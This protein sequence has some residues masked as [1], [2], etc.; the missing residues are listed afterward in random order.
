MSEK[1]HALLV[2][3]SEYEDPHFRRLE[4]PEKDVKALARV[5]GDQALGAFHDVKILLNEPR[6]ALLLQIEEF[7]AERERDDLL[8][9]YFS[10]HG[11]KDE[12]GRLYYAAQN[13][14]HKR[15]VSTAV[16][17]YQVNDLI[18]KSRSR[19]KILLLDCCYSGAFSKAFLAKGDDAVGVMEEFR[20]G[21]GLV[22]L[23]ASDAFQYSFEEEQGGAG[24]VH[25]IFTRALIEGIETGQA[26]ED[27]D[28]LIS[29]DELYHYVYEQ[30]R[31]RNPRQNPRKSGD[32]EGD[33]IVAQNP[34]PPRP[35]ELNPKLQEAIESPFPE[36]REGVVRLLASLLHG[37]NRGLAS[38]AHSALL[39]LQADDSRKVASAAEASL[40]EFDEAQRL[41]APLEPADQGSQSQEKLQVAVAAEAERMARERSEQERLAREQAEE[42]RRAAA[43][44]LVE[45]EAQE[46]AEQERLAWERAE[47]ERLARE[48]AEEERQRAAAAL[49]ERVA[50]EKAEQERLSFKKKPE[51]RP[52]YR[53]KIQ[54]AFSVAF[55]VFLISFLWVD[56][57]SPSPTFEPKPSAPHTIDAGPGSEIAA[58]ESGK[59]NPPAVPASAPVET[60]AHKTEPA[61]QESP[62]RR[63]SEVVVPSRKRKVAESPRAISPAPSIPP[64][65]TKEAPS[66]EAASH[67]QL[68]WKL[69][70]EKNWDGAIAEYRQA[71]SRKPDDPD[72]RRNLATALFKK[73]DLDGAIAEYRETLR[74]NPEDLLAH[75]NL[76]TALSFKGNLDGAIAE[77]RQV[78]RRTP[79]DAAAHSS[80]ANSLLRKGDVDSAIMEYRAALRLNPLD[81][82][83][84]HNLGTALSA[85]GDWDGAIGEYREALRLSPDFPQARYGLGLALERKADF[86]GALAELRLAQ[87]SRP[88]SPDIRAAY[89]RVSAKLKRPKLKP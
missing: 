41:K 36:V 73:G 68:A 89:E 53:F 80:L 71:L 76:G 47:Q 22:T 11:I 84:H 60:I 70:Q 62:S 38:S 74:L 25:S 1:K 51:P 42:E 32:V 24:G 77:F 55:G 54:L 13:T 21:Q 5:L 30:V 48:Q 9:L 34:R 19:R 43:A 35:V 61:A 75:N 85:K 37:K 17:A 72:A 59:A 31:S 23:T 20:Q 46:R 28:Q 14:L 16:P 78:V 6:D 69:F 87:A 40:K 8:L 26:D 67:S 63:P 57:R 44:A 49:A 66:A 56:F 15:L 82:L 79:D 29:L 45:R 81:S 2:A 3:S 4:A 33:I 39:K 64:T 50:R 88:D 83:A 86:Q 65:A 12:D 58:K 52:W 10:G 7:F 18:G 27:G